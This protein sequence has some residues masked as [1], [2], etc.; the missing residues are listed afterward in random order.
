MKLWEII[1]GLRESHKLT[2]KAFAKRIGRSP[3]YVSIIERS[4]DSGGTLP[5]EKALREI[6]SAFAQTEDDRRSLEKKLLLARAQAKAP[7]EI[8]GAFKRDH[9]VSPS[10][11]KMP[12][13]FISRLGKDVASMQE[14]SREKFYKS[15][16]ID[17]AI[18]EE[19]VKGVFV[20]SRASV[21]ELAQKLNQ[22]VEEY[23]LLSGYM[24]E[25]LKL[26]AE[27]KEVMTLFRSLGDLTP[28]ELDQL[29]QVITGVL[30]LHSKTHPS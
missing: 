4:P 29:L 24:P 23:L 2:Q 9:E 28:A 19:A 3:M 16:T 5:S 20:L 15:L 14:E 26:I 6:A 21:V 12:V 10:G 1:K 22:S 18:V 13:A 17:R 27:K 25:E 8:A 30:N 11:E 7:S